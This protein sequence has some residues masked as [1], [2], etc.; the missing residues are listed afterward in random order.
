[1]K[2]ILFLFPLIRLGEIY[3]WYKNQLNAFLLNKYKTKIIYLPKG[4]KLRYLK[5]L[6]NF[7]QYLKAIK[8]T[9][10]V[11]I[12]VSYLIPLIF[13]LTKIFNKKLILGYNASSLSVATYLKIPN[14]I[15]KLFNLLEKIIYPRLD[16]ITTHTE[17][18]TAF[19]IKIY[20]L[21][22]KKIITI[23]NTVD[24]NIFKKTSLREIRR[25]KQELNIKNEK[26]LL[27][28]GC[29][30]E[31]HGLKY[32]VKAWPKIKKENKNLRVVFVGCSKEAASF[33][34]SPKFTQEKQIIF[35]GQVPPSKLPSY[36]SLADIWFGR[37]SGAERSQ[38]CF[39]PCMVEAMSLGLPVLVSKTREVDQFLKE[40][41]N[42][43]VVSPNNS[44]QISQKI[45]FY[46]KN[47]N[48]LLII[49]KNARKTIMENFTIKKM[50]EQLNLKKI[51][52]NY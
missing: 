48:R 12:P 32:F 31:A 33:F 20:N 41:I 8:K 27:Y 50:S 21:N 11:F 34:L 37:F 3:P 35:I 19:L 42:A 23:Y 18:M 13:I 15:K 44:K 9:D 10:I 45:N 17:S 36:L 26:I 7:P 16:L 52:S 29:F 2:K 22:P 40:G 43:I 28:H 25:L 39:S 30:H 5:F 24:P 46:L 47:K 1:M 4:T 14:S 49:G 51:L 6:F 38:R